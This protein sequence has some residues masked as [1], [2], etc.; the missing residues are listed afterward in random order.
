MDT[1]TPREK[2][3]E[4]AACLLDL[5]TVGCRTFDGVRPELAE[6]YREAG[7][8]AFATFVMPDETIN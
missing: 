5:A 4:R 2:A 8:D 7:M 1:R 6:R 3:L